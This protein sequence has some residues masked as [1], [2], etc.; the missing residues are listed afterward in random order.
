LT[1]ILTGKVADSLTFQSTGTPPQTIQAFRIELHTLLSGNFVTA[2][3]IYIDYYIGHS[4]LS[5]GTN[6]SGL[7]RLKLRPFKIVTSVITYP[8]AGFDRIL[9]SYTIAP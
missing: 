4:H 8:V 5:Y 6:P 7:V 3:D 9:Q 2:A 1:G